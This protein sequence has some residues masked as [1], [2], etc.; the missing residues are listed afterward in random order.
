VQ[1]QSMPNIPRMYGQH[2]KLQ[3]GGQ[4]HPKKQEKWSNN[5]LGGSIEPSKDPTQNSFSNIIMA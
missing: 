2:V 3:K 1:K 4:I 5:E